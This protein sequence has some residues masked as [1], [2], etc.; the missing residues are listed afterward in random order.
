MKYTHTNDKAEA[1]GRV[2]GV[3]F[4][5]VMLGLKRRGTG[6]MDGRIDMRFT[7]EYLHTNPH[8]Q[9]PIFAPLVCFSPPFSSVCVCVCVHRRRGEEGDRKPGTEAVK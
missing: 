3:F 4:M 1:S 7:S 6:K 8:A 5:W 9:K 2:S